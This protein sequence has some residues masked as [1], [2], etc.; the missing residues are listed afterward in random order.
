[1]KIPLLIPLLLALTFFTPLRS[2]TPA[3]GDNSGV[4]TYVPP[5]RNIMPLTINHQPNPAQPPPEI[6]APIDKFFS[7]LKSGDYVAA[8][9]NFLAGTRLE[10]QTEKKSTFVSKT[11]D[12]FGIY[13]K[14]TDWEVFDNYSIGHNVVVLTYLSRHPVQPLRWRFIFYRPDKNWVLINMGFDDVLLDLLD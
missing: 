13:G 11:E 1:M 9:D 8:Y 2:Q 10:T 3:P 6:R 7:T 4:Q 14:L 5:P 12:A